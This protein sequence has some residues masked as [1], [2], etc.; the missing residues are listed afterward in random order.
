MAATKLRSADEALVAKAAE[1][2][3]EFG[4]TKIYSVVDIQQF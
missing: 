2:W 4:Q 1:Q 3:S